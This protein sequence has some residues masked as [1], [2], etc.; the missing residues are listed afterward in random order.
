MPHS[1][2]ANVTLSVAAS[3]R[4]L[5]FQTAQRSY[6]QVS[7]TSWEAGEGQYW[8]TWRNGKWLVP[9]EDKQQSDNERMLGCGPG[10]SWGRQS[11]H[12]QQ[13]EECSRNQDAD[14]VLLITSTHINIYRHTNAF[15]GDREM[16]PLAWGRVLTSAGW[17]LTESVKLE[18]SELFL[19][20]DWAS[21]YQGN[22]QC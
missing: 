11:Q 9:Q 16:E 1:H 20:P 17:I 18:G 8:E 12:L 4:E 13:D 22:Q 19:C 10:H 21:H 7:R 3:A 2:T 15:M 14:F 5:S 6:L